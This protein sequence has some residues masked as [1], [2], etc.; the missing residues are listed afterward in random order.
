ME[1]MPEPQAV[2]EMIAKQEGA[3]IG[4]HGAEAIRQFGLSTQMQ[5]QPVFCTTGSSRKINMG[6]LNIRLSHVAPRKLVLGVRPGGQ[7][8]SAVELA[9]IVVLPM[10]HHL[11]QAFTALATRAHVHHPYLPWLTKGAKTSFAAVAHL[12]CKT[13]Q[14]TNQCQIHCATTGKSDSMRVCRPSVH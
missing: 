3:Q 7:A 4:I 13:M 9:P 11:S 1:A 5:P 12:L 2:A 6:G 14:P 8:L 10:R